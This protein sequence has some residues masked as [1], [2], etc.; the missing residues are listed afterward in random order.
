MSISSLSLEEL[1]KN[2]KRLL[3]YFNEIE[4]LFN[5]YIQCGG[6]PKSMYELLE[7]GRIREETYE[8]YWKWLI[9]DIAKIDR[10]ERI[11]TSVLLG[12]LKNYGTR[13]SLNSIAKE[14]E[15]GSHVT[16]REY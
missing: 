6:F 3:F 14:M 16:E 9:A 4:K 8:I 11:T 15:I 13:F 12:V 10:S 2:V 1:D 5:L 7:N